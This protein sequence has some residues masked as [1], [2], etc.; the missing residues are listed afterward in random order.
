MLNG[1]THPSCPTC[2]APLP[3][4]AAACGYCGSQARPALNDEDLKRACQTFVEALDKDI[5][6]LATPRVVIGFLLF[7]LSIPAAY[8]AA[9]ALGAGTWE[10]VLA[11][12]S[13]GLA[14]MVAAGINLVAEEG[15]RFRSVLRPQVE[16]F[17]R[18]HGMGREEFLLVAHDTLE[19]S[20][21]LLKHL[22]DLYGS[23]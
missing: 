20:S 16:E 22:D 9:K 23:P 2:G 12:V 18:R 17:L 14:A 19:E 6:E 10:A 4:G 3:A 11:T 8:F 21:S 13:I 15:R 1:A 7:L 5:S